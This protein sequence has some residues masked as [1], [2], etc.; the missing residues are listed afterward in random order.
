MA[1]SHQIS[2]VLQACYAFGATIAPLIA[3]ALAVD[4]QPGWFS[5]YYVMTAASAVELI[6]SAASF[7]SQ[8]GSVY[9]TENPMHSGAKSGRTRMALKSKL[10]WIFA[11]FIFGYCGAEGESMEL[12]TREIALP[13]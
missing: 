6:T 7:W 3:T 10:T 9:L 13:Y 4:G 11:I 5:F 1:N 2:G 12:Q 8:T